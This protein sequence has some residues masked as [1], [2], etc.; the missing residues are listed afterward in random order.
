MV[1]LSLLNRKNSETTGVFVDYGQ[2]ALSDERQASRRVTDYF[3]T[4][5]IGLRL[6]LPSLYGAGEVRHR[7]GMLIF[8]AA[9]ATAGIADCI[10]IGVHAGV[11]YSD[12]S[13]TFLAAME[14]ALKASHA[15]SL[16]LIAPLK[17]WMKAD[18]IAYAKREGLPIELEQNPIRLAHILS[19]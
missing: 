19:F 13:Q 7:N 6:D 2:A 17:T 18:I 9:M 10:A 16:Q 4:E 15:S 14:A 11:P 12:C 1:V 8:A 5:L 3:E